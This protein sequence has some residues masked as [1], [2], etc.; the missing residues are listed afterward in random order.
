MRCNQ[1][2]LLERLETGYE[3]VVQSSQPLRGIYPALELQIWLLELQWFRLVFV[4]GRPSVETQISGYQQSNR[5]A[6]ILG[7]V[8]SVPSNN[9]VSKLFSKTPRG[10]EQLHGVDRGLPQLNKPTINVS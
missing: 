8:E 3:A 2:R 4:F 7:L 10:I 9:T 1:R 5:V 6:R